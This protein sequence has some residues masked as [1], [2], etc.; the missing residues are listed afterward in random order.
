MISNTS[1]TPTV[2]D[3]TDGNKTEWF[4]ISPDNSSQCKIVRGFLRPG[5]LTGIILVMTSDSPITFDCSMKF[6]VGSVL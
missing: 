5:T 3:S 1:D 2:G 6:Q 4:T